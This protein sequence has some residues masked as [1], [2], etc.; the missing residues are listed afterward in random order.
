VRSVSDAQAVTSSSR[1][2]RRLGRFTGNPFAKRV[3][4]CVWAWTIHSNVHSHQRKKNHPC[5]RSDPCRRPYPH[6][7]PS[8]SPT[9]KGT[10]S[11]GKRPPL[12]KRQRQN[13]YWKS[14]PRASLLTEQRLPRPSRTSTHSV[15]GVPS[16]PPRADPTHHPPSS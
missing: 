7:R 6:V 4:A 15:H 3:Y 10:C 14:R 9:P 11:K 12:Q 16:R 2:R 8:R 13:P 1:R 5:K